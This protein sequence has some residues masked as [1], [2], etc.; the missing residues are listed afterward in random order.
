MSGIEA[1]S[2][3]LGVPAFAGA[4][5]QAVGDSY[6]LVQRYK[7]TENRKGLLLDELR[8]TSALLSR[9]QDR[10]SDSEVAN[11]IDASQLHAWVDRCQA[12]QHDIEVHFGS[13]TLPKLGRKEKLKLAASEDPFTS[14]ERRVS[15]DRSQLVTILETLN[16]YV[17][18]LP[19]S[20]VLGL[21]SLQ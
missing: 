6:G 10:L 16:L 14:F 21:T 8:A 15:G 1:G 18:C 9:L 5:L 19:S 2:A 20:S 4:L 17:Q 3:I 11:A 13:N 12:T 7:A